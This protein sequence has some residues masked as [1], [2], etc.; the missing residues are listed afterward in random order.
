MKANVFAQRHKMSVQTERDESMHRTFL[1]S[2][3][4]HNMA[5]QILGKEM[6]IEAN[7]GTFLPGRVQH[8]SVQGSCPKGILDEEPCLGL[9]KSSTS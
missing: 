6:W 5:E 9:S 1:E 2:N 8:F 3:E 7:G 4:V